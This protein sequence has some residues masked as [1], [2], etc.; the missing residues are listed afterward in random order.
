MITTIQLNNNV[1]RL[2]DNMKET[3]KETY[4]E[5]IVTMMKQLEKQKRKKQELLIAGYKEMS[6]ESLKVAKEFEAL[7]DLEEWKW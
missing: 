5:V 3:G 2:L 1:K 6:E 4:E 7:E